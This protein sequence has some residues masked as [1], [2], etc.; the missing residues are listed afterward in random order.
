MAEE[1]AS[2]RKP[3]APHRRPVVASRA[4][5]V[6]AAARSPTTAGHSLQ[7]RFGNRGT[8][9]LATQVVARSNSG[10]GSVHGGVASGQFTLSQPG[11][12]QE[13]EADAVAD[14]VM[15][16]AQPSKPSSGAPP[17]ASASLLGVQRK[18]QVADDFLITPS[19]SSDIRALQGGGTPLPA[20]SR[21]F[22]EPRFGADFGDVRIHTDAHAAST[23]RSINARA[24]TVGRDIAFGAG[25]FS[26]ESQAGRQLLAHELTHVVQQSGAQPQA[27]RQASSVQRFRWPWES[28]PGPEELK[29]QAIAGDADA[30]DDLTDFSDFTEEQRLKMVD[31]VVRLRWVDSDNEKSLE[32]IWKSFGTDFTR[33]AGANVLRWNNSAVRHSGL[34]DAIPEAKRTRDAFVGD[35]TDVA[36]RNLTINRTYADGEMERLGIPKDARV[37]SAPPTQSQAGELARLQVAAEGIAKLQQSQEIARGAFVGYQQV[38]RRSMSDTPAYR[39]VSF[40]TDAPPSLTTLPGGA[41]DFWDDDHQ[42]WVSFNV[43]GVARPRGTY[44]GEAEEYVASVAERQR[45][46]KI[47]AYAPMKARYDEVTAAIAAHLTA[48]PQ[49]YALSMQGDSAKSGR[50]ANAQSPE[51]ARG[52]LAEAF[53]TLLGNIGRTEER[54]KGKDIDPL[55]FTP[56]HQ[57]LY[58]GKDKGPSG[59]AW[60]DHFAR[61]V[62]EKLAFNHHIDVVLKQL[63]LQQISQLAF[64]FAP[65]AGPLA[66]PLMMVGTTAAGASLVL[67]SARYAALA[68]AA[69]SAAKPGTQLVSK[70][71][72]D[73]ARMAA[74]ADTLAFALALIALGSAAA[75][76][77][78][79]RFQ[80]GQVAR[81]NAQRARLMAEV[82]EPSAVNINRPWEVPYGIPESQ[83]QVVNPGS[84]LNFD[85]MNPNRRYLWVLDEGGN[86]RIADEGQGTNFPKRGSLP[87]EHPSAGESPLK[88][89][90]LTP[91][92]D[93]QSRGVARAG[94]D[95]QAQMGPDGKP[96]G[97]WYM[98]NDS[99]YSFNRQ[100]AAQITM[101]NLEAAKEL[102]K[103]TG[104]DTSRIILRSR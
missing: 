54:L 104:T 7:Q 51:E 50:L 97:K 18:E 27:A 59:V 22:F 82:G 73:E 61:A 86:F 87:P 25:E 63:I 3:S 66:F 74:E 10:V 19:V 1:R 81:L 71:A 62:G 38:L 58:E 48:F 40:D 33:V 23:A 29:K 34:Y 45:L 75:S 2:L 98:N 44:P 55:D 12:A 37:K 32:R 83:V 52:V 101:K 21:A 42:E 99:S 88:H 47:V 80:A 41:I 16:M 102:L 14:K 49:L 89:G 77:A 103:T 65:L 60:N 26:P 64:L 78:I 30:I 96:T 13:R 70:G 57:R 100:D 56:L 8:N 53:R 85:R 93:R 69:G 9:T 4:Q 28:K 46:T 17:P 76:A 43:L 11:D 6:A 94:G 5:P 79:R 15:R 24:F 91:S 68:D 92:A 67:D 90:D 95:L 72:V 36:T 35:V 84:P 31:A 20:S 39:R